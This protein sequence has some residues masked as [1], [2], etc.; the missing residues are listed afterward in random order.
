M[1]GAS[2]RSLLALAAALLASRLP[3]KRLRYANQGDLKSLDPYT[4]NETTTNA[5][6]GHVYEGLTERGKDLK[7]EP[8]LAER[9]EISDD[10]LTWRFHLRKGVKFHDGNRFHRRRR[11]LLGDAR[12]RA[13]AR[14]SRPASRP[15]AEFVKV[16][17]HTVDVK[18]K[19]AEPDP[20]LPVG[21][22]V[23]HGQ[24]VGGGEQRRRARRRPPRRRRA[25]PRSTPTAP[26]RS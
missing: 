6:L 16:D 9:W 20:E 10:G 18:L 22:L 19:I 14:T 26:G 4:L 15:N 7:I 25:M 2:S 12:A 17:D 1:F 13:R 21:H 3:P 23:H 24:G 11:G 8:G 5:H